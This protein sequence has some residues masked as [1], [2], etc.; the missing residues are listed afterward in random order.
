VTDQPE[1]DRPAPDVTPTPLV[2]YRD[3]PQPTGARRGYGSWI[4]LGLMTAGYL[5]WTLVVY[6]LEPGIR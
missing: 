4:I 5:V 6:F 3:I 1:Q 2:G